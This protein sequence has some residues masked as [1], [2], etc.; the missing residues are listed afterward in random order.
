MRDVMFVLF[1]VLSPDWLGEE[2]GRPAARLE[3]LLPT[4]PSELFEQQKQL[5]QFY[6]EWEDEDETASEAEGAGRPGDKAMQAGAA[7]AEET[8]VSTLS[9]PSFLTEP[10]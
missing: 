5:Q 10:P 9:T 7:G 8:K 1:S 2:R 6:A 4:A 3:A